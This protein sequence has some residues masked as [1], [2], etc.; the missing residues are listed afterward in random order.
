[1]KIP[2]KATSS[3]EPRLVLIRVLAQVAKAAEPPDKVI[4]A[5]IMPRNI[6][7]IT[8]LM[9][10][11]LMLSPSIKR[12]FIWVS[13]YCVVPITEKSLSSKA[14]D[15]IPMLRDNSTRRV[16]IARLNASKAGRIDKGDAVKS[17]RFIFVNSTYAVGDILQK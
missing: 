10:H 15:R 3:L 9:V 4:S 6:K 17:I 1:M 7:K 2:R 11:I 14:P 13:R 8:I 5:V 16:M 12:F